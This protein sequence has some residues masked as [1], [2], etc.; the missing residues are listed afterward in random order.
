MYRYSYRIQYCQADLYVNL[1][2]KNSILPY[3]ITLSAIL[4]RVSWIHVS[5]LLK[6]VTVPKIY[7][8]NFIS[9]EFNRATLDFKLSNKAELSL[10]PDCTHL[11]YFYSRVLKRNPKF[12]LLFP[13]SSDY[14]VFPESQSRLFTSLLL[15]SLQLCF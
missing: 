11:W 9:I 2:Y 14:R 5:F 1:L 3:C 8:V 4:S 6:F 12:T 13:H 7:M 15:I 10:P